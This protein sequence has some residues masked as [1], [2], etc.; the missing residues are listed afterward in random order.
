MEFQY[1][2][3]DSS[4]KIDL[5]SLGDNR[6]KA[7]IGEREIE[8]S[9]QHQGDGVW[10]LMLNNRRIQGTVIADGDMRYVHV[11]GK[12]FTLSAVDERT[13]RRKSSTSAGELSSYA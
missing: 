9:A 4:H 5:I 2:H 10:L 8:L 12:T 13:R 1:S 7:T 11:D 6:Y 3:H